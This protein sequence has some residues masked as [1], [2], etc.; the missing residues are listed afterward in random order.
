MRNF[1]HR[2][3]ITAACVAL[4]AAGFLGCGDSKRNN[5]GVSFTFAGWFSQPGKNNTFEEAVGSTAIPAPISDA[6][7]ESGDSYG[8]IITRFAALQN[9]LTGQMIRAE[10]AYHSYY[11]P[12]ASVQPP[13][14][15]VSVAVV[16]GPADDNSAGEEEWKLP[17]DADTTLPGNADNI[18][19]LVFASVPVVT[20]DVRTFIN[21]NRQY[22]PELPFVM[23]VTTYISGV[24]SS[25]YRLETNKVQIEVIW[26]PDNI[27]P[28]A[29][30]NYTPDEEEGAVEE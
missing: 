23:E 5:Q 6:N 1:N 15:S 25:G 24:A 28:P 12:G 17:F 4:V 13:D 14:T 20:A 18:S 21:T 3:L 10:R 27:I 11:I 7:P 22:M 26:T 19:D 16:L 9:N 30:G 29:G 8:G 2:I